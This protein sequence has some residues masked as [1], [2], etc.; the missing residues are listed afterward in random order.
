MSAQH[1]NVNIKRNVTNYIFMVRKLFR[2]QHGIFHYIS[3]KV[4]ISK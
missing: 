1:R 4:T 3:F 2:L